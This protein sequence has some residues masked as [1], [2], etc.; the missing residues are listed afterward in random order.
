M[1]FASRNW[2]STF[3]WYVTCILVGG[4]LAISLSGHVLMVMDVRA[5]IRSLRRALIVVTDHLPHFPRW[6]RLQSPRCLHSLGVKLPC[7]EEQLLAAYR[8]KVKQ[9]HPDR[10]GNR[11]RFMRMQADFEEALDVIRRTA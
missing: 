1:L 2:P 6:A 9:L 3:D 8:K 4:F 7:T 11:L 10:G 5:W